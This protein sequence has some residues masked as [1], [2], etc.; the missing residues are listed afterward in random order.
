MTG[1]PDPIRDLIADGDAVE[2]LVADLTPAQWATPT[3]AQA[4]RGP[5]GPGRRPGQFA[6]LS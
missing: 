2:R 1:R 4:F 5:A 6:H 3:S